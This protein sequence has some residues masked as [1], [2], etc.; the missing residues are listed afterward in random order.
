[1]EFFNL[2]NENLENL[3]NEEREA[4]IEFNENLKNKIIQELIVYEGD[5]L[6][7]KINS[8]LEDY[9]GALGELLINGVKGYKNMT[10]KQ[11]IDIYLHKKNEEDF[12]R[13]ISN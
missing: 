1:M 4:C 12:I 6:K 3:S 7:A 5:N 2:I 9:Y 10:L 11:L 8:S 13:L